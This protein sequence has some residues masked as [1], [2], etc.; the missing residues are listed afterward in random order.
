DRLRAQFGEDILS[1]EEAFGDAVIT[2]NPPRYVE[3]AQFL[4]DDSDLAFD[5]FDFLSGV[6]Y[7]PKGGGFEVV[8]DVYSTRNTHNI[9]LKVQ[10]D[11]EN[12][13]VPTISHIWPGANWHERETWELM[14]IVFEGHPHLVKLVLPEQFEGFPLRKDFPLMTREAKPWP[15]E[16]EGEEVEE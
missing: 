12:P 15:G 4:H 11:A 6:D 1:A 9:L 3:M 8:T 2:V 10:L 5:F 7:R 13:R 14:G 16:V